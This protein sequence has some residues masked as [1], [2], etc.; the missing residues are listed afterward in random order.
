MQHHLRAAT[1]AL[2]PV[3]IALAGCRPAAG[4]AG[5]ARAE[6]ASGPAAPARVSVARIVFV[7]Q[8]RACG[9]TMDRINAA[10]DVLQ[11][12]VAGRDLAVER[13]HRDTEAA[14]AAPFLA[15]RRSMAAPAV[16]FLTAEGELVDLIQGDLR[17]E[18]IAA[19]LD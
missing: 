15:M 7:D 17:P 4:E 3:L 9:C 14:R 6:A 10:W 5:P 2:V 1:I 8:E 11:A 13:I 18:Q 16:Y 19:L 12:A